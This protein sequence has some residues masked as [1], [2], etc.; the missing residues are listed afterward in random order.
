MIR[1]PA[2]AG[3]FYPANPRELKHQIENL[4]GDA[5]GPKLRARGCVVPH[6]GYMYSGHVA[7]AVFQ[8]LEL[9]AR[10]IILC[11]RHYR[12][13]QPLAIMS[14]G[15][16]RTPLG[17]AKIDSALAVELKN[18]CSL[19][20]EDSVAHRMEHSLEV[21][22]PF[23][24]MLAGDFEFVPIALGTDRFA[25][26][27]ELGRAIGDVVAQCKEA[28][29]LVASSDMNHYESDD[30][31][32][33]KDRKAIDKILE[34]N[35]RGL[36]DTVRHEG[37]TMCGFGPAVSMMTAARHLGAKRAEVI[38]YATSGD[39]TGDRDEV[40]GYAGIAVI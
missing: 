30:I 24:Q 5:A 4:L 25:A 8:R 2:V 16:W 37:I 13:G 29:L 18:A 1:E 21:Q 28:V 7:G 32:R 39:V 40:V 6:A 35:P 22:L 14:E 33:A 11:P 31:T 17:E 10:F 27:E 26:L 23:L 36:F 20:R 12:E 34:L 3:R 38:R 9:P 15:S 19:L